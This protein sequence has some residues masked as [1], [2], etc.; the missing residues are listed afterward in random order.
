[1]NV[2]ERF[3]AKVEKRGDDD[4]WLWIG[5][6]NA[7]G[8]G[9][10]DWTRMKG[11]Q[12]I[13]HRFAYQQA[14]GSRIPDGLMVLH[15]CDTP[16]CCNPAH[17]R[18]GSAA[19]NAADRDGRQRQAKGSM[20]GRAKLTEDA[21]RAIRSDPRPH[22]EIAAEHGIHYKKVSPIK[23]RKAWVHVSDVPPLHQ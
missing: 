13:A 1:M 11:A 10:F 3:W 4:C 21:V 9:N 8:Y 17:L 18:L 14:T 6:T 7:K 22:K 5:K 19:D 23:S 15:S 20:H 16:A 12:R 2:L